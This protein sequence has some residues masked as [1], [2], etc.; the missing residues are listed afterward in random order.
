MIKLKQKKNSFDS[1]KCLGLNWAHSH[2][3]DHWEPNK[4]NCCIS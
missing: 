4:I 3:M 1:K 2:G